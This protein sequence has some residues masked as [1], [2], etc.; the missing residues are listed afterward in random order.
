MV[1]IIQ[2]NTANQLSYLG[3]NAI[4]PANGNYTVPS[5]QIQSLSTDGPLQ[6]DIYAANVYITDGTDI[7]GTTDAINY[8]TRMANAFVGSAVGVDGKQTPGFEMVTGGEDPNGKVQAVRVN[9][10]NDL[11]VNNRNKYQNITGNKNVTVK[12]GSGTLHGII[13]NN[14]STGGTVTIFDN[15]TNSGTK[16]GTYTIG[17]PTG[18]LLSSTGQEGPEFVGPLGLEFT[19]GLTIVTAGSTSNDITAVYQ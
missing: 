8:L 16:I 6:A 11:S 12:S 4:V 15:T 14:N 19:T 3:G 10:F 13:I 9:Q 17:T 5:H 7:F 2:N 1:I 18:G